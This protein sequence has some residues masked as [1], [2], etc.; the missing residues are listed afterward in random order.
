MTN[1]QGNDHFCLQVFGDQKTVRL[2]RL[3]F[4]IKHTKCIN[5]RGRGDKSLCTHAHVVPSGIT[6]AE[7]NQTKTH[8]TSG[9][10]GLTD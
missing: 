5:V 3:L 4:A 8:L 10:G 9:D 2:C 6:L 7:H 1:Y